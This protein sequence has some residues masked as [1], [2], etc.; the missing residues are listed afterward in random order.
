M[1]EERSQ[2][3]VRMPKTLLQQIKQGA[4]NEDVTVSEWI[5]DACAKKLEGNQETS[6]TS[7]ESSTSSTI[8]DNGYKS[9]QQN[10]LSLQR[11][12][13]ELR[14]QIPAESLAS[15]TVTPLEHEELKNRLE[16]LELEV[17]GNFADKGI[18]HEIQ[19]IDQWL[20][21]LDNR[22][23]ILGRNMV[24]IF[25]HTNF[26]T[27]NL[28]DRESEEMLEDTKTSAEGDVG[29]SHPDTNEDADLGK[30]SPYP[31]KDVESGLDSN[32]GNDESD[33]DATV[34]NLKQLTEKVGIS[35]STARRQFKPPK[36]PALK[37]GET[38]VIKG[39]RFKI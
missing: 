20:Y 1:P 31:D 16:Q 10:I 33:R 2:I 35:A 3:N 15:N 32:N 13:D 17:R 6:N 30:E 27:P 25:C 26:E 18:Q 24:G 39:H 23:D 19:Q 7:S 12:I 38:F 21:R 34:I 36:K 37:K 8:S 5:K 14:Q 9:L 28:G 11:Q 4:K 29:N 22:I